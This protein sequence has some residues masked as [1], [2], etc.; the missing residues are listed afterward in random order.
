MAPSSETVEGIPGPGGQIEKLSHPSTGLR[1]EA[2]P[3]PGNGAGGCCPSPK[4][5]AST[6]TASETSSAPS[7]FTSAESRQGTISPPKKRTLRIIDASEISTAA[8]TLASPRIKGTDWAYAP[9][10]AEKKTAKTQA[11]QI[12]KTCGKDMFLPLS[13]KKKTDCPAE[14]ERPA[15]HPKKPAYYL[16]GTKLR[17][18]CQFF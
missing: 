11:M 10:L 15:D 16:L 2:T 17:G 8:S 7:A 13:L 14:T 9:W 1:V 4:R 12:L 18:T 5:Y 3:Q 6:P